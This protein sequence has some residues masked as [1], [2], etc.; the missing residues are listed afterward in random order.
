MK[1]LVV[2][3][4]QFPM[5]AC[6]LVLW[7]FCLLI[8]LEVLPFCRWD[9]KGFVLLAFYVVANWLISIITDDCRPKGA[10]RQPDT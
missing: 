2:R 9:K 10:L 7:H 6:G 3:S 5:P 1:S 8:I 4:K